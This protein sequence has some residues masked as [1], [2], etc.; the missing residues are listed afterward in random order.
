MNC[1]VLQI[2]QLPVFLIGSLEFA[3]KINPHRYDE[4]ALRAGPITDPRIG[5]I[6]ASQDEHDR[7]I[8]TAKGAGE[9]FL[10]CAARQRAITRVGVNPDSTELL[11][12]QAGVDPVFEKIGNRFIVEFDARWTTF[13]FY[14]LDVIDE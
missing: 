4:F 3:G 5:R 7:P 2:F 12:F 1:H 10:I 6:I 8:T 11:R 9:G 14:Q 13:L